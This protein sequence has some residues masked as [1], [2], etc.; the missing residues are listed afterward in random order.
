MTKKDKG[1]NNDIQTITKRT[2]N[3]VTGTPL[4]VGLNAGAPVGKQFLL[5]V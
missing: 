2:N 5:H 1:A 3:P 4:S